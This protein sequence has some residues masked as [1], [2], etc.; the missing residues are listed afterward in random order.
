MLKD[1]EKALLLINLGSPDSTEVGDVKRYLREFL[2]DKRVIDA[3]WLIRK[4]IVE[5][6]ILPTRPAQSAEAYKTIW[7]DEGSP[8][9]VISKQLREAV[10]EKSNYHVAL[11]MRYGNPSIANTLRDLQ[12]KGIKQVHCIPL[13]PHYAMSS[14]ETVVEK[15]KSLSYGKFSDMKFSFEPPFYLNSDYLTALYRSI[16]PYTDKEFDHILFS[17]HGVP[18]RHIRKSD[19]TKSHCLQSK[20]CCKV[21][22]DAHAFCYRHQVL[23]TTDQIRLILG[24]SEDKVSSSFQSRLGKDPWLTPFTDAVLAELPK[25]GIKNLLVV[26]PAFVSD[27]LETIEEIGE[28][29]KEIFLNN[30]GEKFTLIPCLNTQ[31]SFVECISNMESALEK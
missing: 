26:C 15:V 16:K 18:E 5:G 8:L 28:E 7:T 4:I 29:G 24:L 23:K 25:K 10:Q 19:I 2:S 31:D 30:G 1:K 3:P 17:Y 11:A 13:Y 27:C 9:I 12:E 21:Q 22:S 14:Y 20:D 6:F